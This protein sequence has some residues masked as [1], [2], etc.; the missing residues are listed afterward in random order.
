MEI[1]PP[2]SGEIIPSLSELVP[3]LLD[4]QPTRKETRRL[5]PIAARTTDDQ[6]ASGKIVKARRRRQ[7]RSITALFSSLE[8]SDTNR[9]R[10][11]PTREPVKRA[12][13]VGKRSRRR[14]GRKADENL[15]A[16]SHR[17]EELYDILAVARQPLSLVENH[18]PIE[19]PD[20]DCDMADDEATGSE[21]GEVTV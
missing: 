1:Q 14:H 18:K 21:E 11:S 6:Q 12:P 20:A 2:D 17:K 3:E 16:G 9:G 15:D 7:R 19:G 13:A 4:W 5:A 8:L 10:K